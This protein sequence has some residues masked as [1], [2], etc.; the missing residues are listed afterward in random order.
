MRICALYF[1][2]YGISYSG[3]KR[4]KYFNFECNIYGIMC[5]FY[6]V[7]F[8]CVVFHFGL[9]E[10]AFEF[11]SA[12][13]GHIHPVAFFFYGLAYYVKDASRTEDLS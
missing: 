8:L 4:V 13:F 11:K 1:V 12:I 10:D 9:M 5:S 3:N 2:V 6:A 7:I